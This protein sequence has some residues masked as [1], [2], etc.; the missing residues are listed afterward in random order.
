MAELRTEGKDVGLASGVYN[1]GLDLGA[2]A[3]PVLGGVLAS[4]FGIPAMFQL[5]AILSLAAY[6][7]VSLS[8]APGRA[9]LSIRFSRASE[10]R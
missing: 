7:A 2:M 3:G 10:S 1:A 4:A 9:A 5:V 6:F 8:S